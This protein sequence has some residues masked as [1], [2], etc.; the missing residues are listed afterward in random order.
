MGWE[1]ISYRIKFAIILPILF[2]I[3]SFVPIL[4]IIPALPI[5]I[6]DTFINM[7]DILWRTAEVSVDLTVSGYLFIVIF[8]A[9]AG[10]V[11]GIVYEK[12]KSEKK[13]SRKSP[14][15]FASIFSIIMFILILFISEGNFIFSLIT[16]I[17]VFILTAIIYYLINRYMNSIKN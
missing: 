9:L 6:I 2:T 7:K 8:W 15:L 1:E 4:S 11:I 12:I 14:F 16:G 17:C 5:F 10:Y 3:I 13:Q